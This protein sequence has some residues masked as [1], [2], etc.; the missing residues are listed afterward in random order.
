LLAAVPLLYSCGPRVEDLDKKCFSDGLV[1]IYDFEHWNLAKQQISKSKKL[2]TG[3]QDLFLDDYVFAANSRKHKYRQETGKYLK[4]YYIVYRKLD[5]GRNRI[6][7]IR[8]FSVEESHFFSPNNFGNC[9]GVEGWF[10]KL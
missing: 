8:G 5:V 9:F 2:Y 7:T 1:K 10:E 3:G 6:A 4:D